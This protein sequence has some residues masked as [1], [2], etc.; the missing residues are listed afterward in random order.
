MNAQSVDNAVLAL[1]ASFRVAGRKGLEEK[2]VLIFSGK[3]VRK[4]FTEITCVRLTDSGWRKL[5]SSWVFLKK[6]KGF[7]S[8]M[9]RREKKERNSAHCTP[10]LEI[11]ETW[12]EL[13]LALAQ[14]FTSCKT[15]SRP[16]LG[17]LSLQSYRFS[18]L[19]SSSSIMKT[20]MLM[21]ISPESESDWKVFW[22][23]L[24]WLFYIMCY[25]PR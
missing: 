9:G 23:G 25:K 1:F 6:S 4:H 3:L 5:T 18:L 17:M 20:K 22:F 16:I 10:P 13:H 8:Q 12:S 14:V 15:I 2:F 21:T 11:Q 7:K 24:P 19:S